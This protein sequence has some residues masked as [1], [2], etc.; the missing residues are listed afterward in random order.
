MSVSTSPASR[1]QP[2]SSDGLMNFAYSWVPAGRSLQD[3]LGA[4]DGEGKCLG[5]AVNGGEVQR[6]AGFGQLGAGGNH[7]ARVRHVLQHLQATHDIEVP[8][9]SSAASVLRRGVAVVH[10]AT[11]DSRLVQPAR[12]TGA[13]RPCRCQ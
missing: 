11:P 2:A 10:F 1:I 7:R 6:G 13:L 5:V 4:D 3:V 12:P 8:R 9:A